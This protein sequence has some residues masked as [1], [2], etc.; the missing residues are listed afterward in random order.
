MINGTSIGTAILIRL[1]MGMKL[2]FL[3]SRGSNRRP[4]SFKG[5]LLQCSIAL[6]LKVIPSFVINFCL[7]KLFKKLVENVK[8][9]E[10]VQEQTK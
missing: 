10:A 2:H 5:I 9:I 6:S 1:N 7:V 4:V 8:D 3:F